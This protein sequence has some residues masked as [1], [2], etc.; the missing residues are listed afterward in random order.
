MSTTDILVAL[1]QKMSTDQ[2]AMQRQLND[3]I[4]G[5]TPRGTLRD[6][7]VTEA[8]SLLAKLDY[9]GELFATIN[10]KLNA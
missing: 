10:G 6:S 5:A 3:I 8:Y 9:I 7:E 1:V 4:K 2:E